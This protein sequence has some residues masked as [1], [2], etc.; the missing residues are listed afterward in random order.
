MHQNHKQLLQIFALVVVVI[1]CGTIA[2]SILHSPS[3]ETEVPLD[4]VYSYVGE[5]EDGKTLYLFAIKQGRQDAIG[6]M[7]VMWE[8]AGEVVTVTTEI[9][10][11]RYEKETYVY[12]KFDCIFE[13]WGIKNQAYYVTKTDE[14]IH[15]GKYLNSG[16]LDWEKV[17]PYEEFP[18][19]PERKRAPVEGV[20]EGVW[21]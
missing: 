21:M 12:W 18:I 1:V 10:G 4:G 9:R 11:K 3:G 2:L 7:S 17:G 20:E 6:T 8:E 19:T 16:G 13:G 14:G 15:V 5:D